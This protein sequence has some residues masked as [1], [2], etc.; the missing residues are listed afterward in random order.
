MTPLSRPCLHLLPPQL[1]TALCTRMQA[2]QQVR[3]QEQISASER[4]CRREG[5]KDLKHHCGSTC[6]ATLC[7]RDPATAEAKPLKSRDAGHGSG[8]RT[9]IACSRNCWRN[10]LIC[11]PS[12]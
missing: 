11:L 8:T 1:K 5:R 10:C 2:R 12:T 9:G 6:D 7:S 4:V 3:R